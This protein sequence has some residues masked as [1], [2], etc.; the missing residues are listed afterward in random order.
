[1]KTNTKTTYVWSDYRVQFLRPDRRRG[2]SRDK[3]PGRRSTERQ[4]A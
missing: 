1:M 3:G 2:E 4:D